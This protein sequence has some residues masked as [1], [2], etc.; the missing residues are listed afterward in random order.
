MSFSQNNYTIYFQ[1]E[2]V[3][4]PE[5]IETFSWNQLPEKSEFDNGYI[6]WI[7]FFE[8][9]SQSIQNEFKSRN[10]ELLEYIPHKAY[11]FHF[12]ASTSV[13]FLR[14]SG[15]RGIIP[16]DA[17]LKISK[18]L[19][20]PPFEPWAMDGENILVTLQFHKN[21]TTQYVIDEL[22]K[23]QI[24]VKQEY[25]NA[26]L[27]DLS[28]PD[29]CLEELANLPFVK[30]IELIVPPDVKDDTRGKSLHRSNSLDTQS[31]TGNNYTGVGVGV[32][33]RD[34]GIVGPHIDFQGRIDN[35]YASGTGQTHGDGV[36]GIMAGA[37]NLNPTMRGMAAGAD[38][39]VS[40]YV[41]NFLDT[42]TQN[43]INSGDVQITNSSYSNGCNAG[44]T[45]IT[46]TVDQQTITHPSVMHVFSAGNSNNNNCGYGAGTQ[47][48]NI[49]GGHKQGK[50]VI[51]TANVFFD[52][53]LVNSSSRGPATDG[54]IK[55]DITANG[56]GQNSTSE[57]NGYLVFGGT[58]GAAPGIAGVSAQLYE[59]YA[60]LNGG[61]LPPS[62]LI[63]ATL[64]NTANDYGNVGPDF[65]FGWGIVNG[66]R[67]GK[68][69][70]DGRYLSDDISQGNTNTH[71][72]NVPTGTTQVRFMVYWSDPAA[73]AGAN[74]ALVNDLDL[75]VKDPSDDS[76]LPWILDPTPNPTN[77][78]TPATTGIDRLNNMEQV[79]LNNP[80]SGNYTIEVTGFNVP[81]GPQEYFVV[82][83]IITDNLTVTYPNGDEH[84]VPS[85]VEA[86][87]WDATNTTD[88]FILEYSTN[89]GT[90]WNNI[91]TV[92]S[93][94]RIYSWAVPSTITGEARI[95][96]TS[97]SF[98]DSSDDY[99][100][101]ANLVSG[102]Q[103]TQVCPDE[104]TFT[105]NAMADANEYDLYMLGETYM[106]VAGTSNTTSVTVPITDPSAPIYYA[107]SAKNTTLGWE[108]RRTNALFYSGGLLNCSL[109]NDIALV[110]I[111]NEPIDFNFVCDEDPKIINVTILN[112]GIEP[113]NGFTMRYQVDGEPPVEEVY[114]GTLNSGQQTEFEFAVPLVLTTSGEYTLTASVDL[115]GDQNASNDEEVLNFYS[116]TEAISLDFMEDFE[117]NGFPPPGWIILNPDND[118]TWEERSGI[119]GSDGNSTT[120]GFLNNFSYNAQGEEDAFLTEIF[121]LTNA[122][123]AV[124]S[125]DLAK[126][127]YS[128]TFSDAMRVELSTDCGETF[129]TI[130]EKSGLDLSTMPSYITSNWTPTAA[131]NWRTEEVDLAAY[132]GENVLVKFVNING[133]G[134]STYVDNINM[135]GVLDVRDLNQNS[136]ALYPNPAGDYVFLSFK[137]IPEGDLEVIITNTL[138][139]KVS[140]SKSISLGRNN[141]TS[142]DISAYSSGLYFVSVK[143]NDVTQVKKLVIK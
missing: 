29:N 110:S 109:A 34:D 35:T 62:A 41:A 26:N 139:Q 133:Y 106:E 80:A 3:E 105:W 16:V 121:D 45:T 97:G 19:N 8:T 6:G 102:L 101:I 122:T 75:V 22:A 61:I 88:N 18:E 81:M 137:N 40:N 94:L 67:A 77:L 14:N 117:T 100:S 71:T 78:D 114:A 89:G 1:D 95:R 53:S 51:A 44:Y 125:F 123:S 56:Q 25:K 86:I 31:S 48:G 124:L 17:A 52:G 76:F 96:V 84:F 12:P 66:N 70:E 72:I 60:S 32:L 130:Y 103:I 113:Q 46:N 127:Q 42:G 10:L 134:N 93:N 138:G 63:K 74:P 49:T 58:S 140:H 64:L 36:A 7:Q 54:R 30:W 116:A 23:L 59:L 38:V 108:G 92:N 118:D 143:H 5:N 119:T 136:F 21:V 104:A 135:E 11:L 120:A 142:F 68:L 50:N 37:G 39:Y 15:V 55:P 65:K 13:E 27:I 33:V 2:I 129:T 9:P 90:S 85:E 47:W 98:Q 99:F 57:N 24:V 79:L 20:Y 126:A 87:H 131:S 4:I 132:L 128:A 82:Y 83:E 111:N 91:A 115:A 73:A 69:I 28:I 112:S 43:L 141:T 107:V